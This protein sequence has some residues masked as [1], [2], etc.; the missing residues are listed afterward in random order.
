ML[1]VDLMHKFELGVFKSAFKHVLR[2]LYVINQD[3]IEVI[4]HRYVVTL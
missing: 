3:T 1:T 4:N 2:L